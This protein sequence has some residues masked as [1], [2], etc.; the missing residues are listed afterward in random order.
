MVKR[1][2]RGDGAGWSRA[3]GGAVSHFTAPLAAVLCVGRGHFGLVGAVRQGVVG[4]ARKWSRP[5]AQR[6]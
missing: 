2:L 5:F 3:V 4:G 6:G 1:Q